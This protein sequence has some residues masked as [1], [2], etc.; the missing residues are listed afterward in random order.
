MQSPMLRSQRQSMTTPR[1]DLAA[2]LDLLQD[3]VTVQDAGGRVVYA[4]MVAARRGG[5]S[6]PEELLKSDPAEYPGRY[7]LFDEHGAPFPWNRL[8]GRLVLAGLDAPDV[9]IRYHDEKTDEDHWAI[10]HAAPLPAE[11]GTRSVVNVIRDVTEQVTA[12]KGLEELRRFE[13][14]IAA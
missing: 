14:G 9:L 8:P 6:T 1:P 2:V 10:V 12:E 11:A 5:F 13:Q 7:T 4:N 3:S